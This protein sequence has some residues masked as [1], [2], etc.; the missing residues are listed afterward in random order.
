MSWLRRVATWLRSGEAGIAEVGV[1]STLRSINRVVAVAA[2]AAASLVVV[3]ALP[4]AADQPPPSPG[5]CT[6]TVSPNPVDTFPADVTVSGTAPS[7]V[8]VTVFVN[9]AAD[10]SS[11][12]SGGQFSIP[13]HLTAASD[14]SVNY[15]FGNKN[16]Y[17]TGCAGPGGA[18]VVRVSA[19][20][21][22]RAQ[23]GQQA[24]QLA[25]TG[26]N[27]TPSFILIGVAALIVGIVLTV[28]ARRRA[29]VNT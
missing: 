18:T 16:A 24:A 6:F 27:N 10:G 3:F 2:L 14:I 21:A 5:P 1:H 4:A 29:R 12:A 7:G 13:V 9:G 19:Q 15:T 28:G 8:T 17:S 11:V 22:Q 25:F 23:Q 20:E 26:S